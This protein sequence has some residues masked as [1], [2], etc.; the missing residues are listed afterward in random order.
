ME[1]SVFDETL[2]KTANS[3][4]QQLQRDSKNDG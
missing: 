3:L 1:T 2:N 4:A